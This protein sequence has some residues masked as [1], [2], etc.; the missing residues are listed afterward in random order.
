MKSYVLDN[1]PVVITEK[2]LLNRIGRD[3]RAKISKRFLKDMKQ[4]VNLIARKAKPRAVYRIVPV[5]TN[6]GSITFDD[7]FLLKSRKLKRIFRPCQKAVIFLTTIGPQVDAIIQR[8][9]KKKPSFGYVLDS[10]ASVAVESTANHLEKS[11]K[12]KF[13]P[14]N[15]VTLRYSPGY[16]DWPLSEQENIF[17][18]IPGNL[19]G[20]ELSERFFMMPHKSISGALGVCPADSSESKRNACLECQNLNCPYRRSRERD[21]PLEDKRETRLIS[22][23]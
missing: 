4:A 23:R 21:L 16:C 6:N 5:E 14:E 2:S 9:M 8:T 1:I 17:N 7:R 12:K 22:A 18:I 20:V 13:A 3:S 11:F 10:A 19:I 15:A